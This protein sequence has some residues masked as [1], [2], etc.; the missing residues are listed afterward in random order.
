MLKALRIR[1]FRLLWLGSLVSALGSWLLNLALP[2]HVFLVTG[3]LRDTGLTLAAQYLPTL[4]LGPVAGVLVDRWD[5]RRV[6]VATS[7]FRAT[8]VAV[9]LLGTAPGRYWVLYAALIGE[10]AGGVLY[11]PAARARTPAIVGTGPVLNRANALNALAGGVVQLIGGPLGGILLP[12]LGINWLICADALSYLFSAATT[13]MT[14]RSPRD[15]KDRPTSTR[16]TTTHQ[17]ATRAVAR[18]TACRVAARQAP[19]RAVACELAEGVRVL[20]AQP[21]ARAL[22]PVTVIFLAANASLSSVFI[23]FG[24]Q[25]LGGSEHTGF[26][27]SALGV[28][29]LLGAPALRALLDRGQPRTLMTATLTATAFAYFALF[30][31]SSL[32]TALPAAVAIGMFGSMSEVIPQTAIQRVIP[33]ATLGRVSAVF[34]TGEAAATLLGAVA[35]PFLAQAIH[36]TGIAAIASSTTLLAALLAFLSCREHHPAFDARGRAPGRRAPGRRAPG[37]RAASGQ[38]Q[39]QSRRPDPH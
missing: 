26:L 35:G 9:M 18:L 33:D 38:G 27:L 25:R 3:S 2:A 12:V 31:S 8:S 16:P 19:I 17:T 22:L 7:L 10:S 14:S 21:V 29:V 32:A 15:Q 30:T 39:S 36:L 28:G 5:R 11:T 20:R 23:P 1:D 13:V 4:V 37:R 34:L 24:V 6:M